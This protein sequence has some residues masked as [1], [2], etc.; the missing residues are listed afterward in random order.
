MTTG[1]EYTQ[2]YSYTASGAGSTGFQ[3]FQLGNTL[4]TAGSVFVVKYL[5]VS[6]TSGIANSSPAYAVQVVSATSNV[7][8]GSLNVISN[9]KSSVGDNV[10]LALL[11]N[12]S[13][14]AIENEASQ[15]ILNQNYIG[16]NVNMVAA[17]TFTVAISYSL[18]PVA[19]TLSGN[20]G[21]ITDTSSINLSILDSGTSTRILKSAIVS[22]FDTT[23]TYTT[24]FA[25]YSG[26]S[27]VAYL[28]DVF[29][30]TPGDSV[31]YS[32]PLYLT[33]SSSLSLEGIH[34]LTPG[35]VG[36]SS[37]CSY[38]SETS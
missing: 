2:V 25:I 11:E 12:I 35:G 14:V 1:I 13:N 31:C 4:Q 8:A 9:K 18:I 32:F 36:L 20:F 21:V 6:S 29:T 3:Y 26:G 22:N 5:S 38:I 7:G 17:G 37:Y 23:E 33:T 15:L 24:Q 28:S 30:L 27:P 34:T 19:N 16:I 10:P